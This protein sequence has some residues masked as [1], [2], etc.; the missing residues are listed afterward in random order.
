MSVFSI[1]VKNFCPT[2]SDLSLLRGILGFLT[3]SPV[4]KHMNLAPSPCPV[5]TPLANPPFLLNHK[6]LIPTY[7]PTYLPTCLPTNLPPYL[8]TYQPTF[9]PAYLPTYVITILPTCL[10]TCL[11]ACLPA[12]LATYLPAEAQSERAVFQL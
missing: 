6:I 10:P 4:H 12:Y 5:L 9:L 2:L 3:K 1:R 7:Q 8:P 11:S